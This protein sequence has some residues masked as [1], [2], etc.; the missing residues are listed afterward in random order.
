MIKKT[1]SFFVLAATGITGC[2]PVQAPPASTLL[3]SPPLAA[4]PPAEVKPVTLPYPETRADHNSETLFGTS[5]DDPYRW[6][7][8]A[9]AEPVKEWMAAQDR[10]ARDQLAAIPGR[11]ALLARLHALYYIDSIS[12]P[13]HRGTRYF[14]TRTHADKEKAIV[15]WREGE[16]G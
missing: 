9:K 11:D 6:L 1:V 10:L 15:Y 2:V 8:D 14:Y 12:A 13:H 3:N 16:A 4:A 7:E 5:I